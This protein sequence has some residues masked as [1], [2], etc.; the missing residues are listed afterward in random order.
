M[1]CTKNAG[2][3]HFS[4]LKAYYDENR[5]YIPDIK[6]QNTFIYYLKKYIIR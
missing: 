1:R 4:I 6:H 2:I 5:G 3:L